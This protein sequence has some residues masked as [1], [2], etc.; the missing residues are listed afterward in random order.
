VERRTQLTLAIFLFV[1][2]IAVIVVVYV[3][4]NGHLNLQGN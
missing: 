3:L 2:L 4:A 1:A